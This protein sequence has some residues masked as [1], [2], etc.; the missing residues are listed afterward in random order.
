MDQNKYAANQLK[1]MEILKKGSVWMHNYQSGTKYELYQVPLKRSQFEGLKFKNVCMILYQKQG[2]FLIALEIRIAGKTKVF[3]NP[4]D[5]VFDA[6]DH[7]GYVIHSQQPSYGFI[8]EIDLR[9]SQARNFFIMDH[10]NKQD[11]HLTRREMIDINL[12][13]AREFEKEDK[14]DKDSDL[15]NN[16]FVNSKPGTLQGP[17]GAL[18]K[19]KL[20]GIQDHIIVCGIVKGIKNLI[21]PLR[22]RF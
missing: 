19:N 11:I 20:K 4:Y 9:K 3:V 12:K 6:C 7:Y 10:L 2:L 13:L 16:F 22:S 1:I 14:R 17:N 8:N 18:Q 21:L 15:E 5:Y